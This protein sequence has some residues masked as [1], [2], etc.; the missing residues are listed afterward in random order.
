MSKPIMILMHLSQS[1]IFKAREM[2]MWV[3]DV[4]V[5][6]VGVDTV[7]GSLLENMRDGVFT[8][9]NMGKWIMV[10]GKTYTRDFE[11]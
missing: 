11:R 8:G 7:S 6:G 3:N 2:K 1:L 9:L 10:S 4:L 5:S